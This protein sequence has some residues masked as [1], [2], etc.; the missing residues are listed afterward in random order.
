MSS[1]ISEFERARAK[2]FASIPTEREVRDPLFRNATKAKIFDRLV[3]NR[4]RKSL[5]T[6]GPGQIAGVAY[7]ITANAGMR[8]DPHIVK[9]GEAV[10]ER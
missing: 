10:E 1:E 2:A 6:A 4:I 8:A 5:V 7:E 3:G 9:N